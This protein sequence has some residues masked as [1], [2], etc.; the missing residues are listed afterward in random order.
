M[1]IRD[2]WKPVVILPSG[3]HTWEESA[4][5]HVL[6]HEWTHITRHDWAIASFAAFA[7][8]VFWFNPLVWWIERKLSSL[9]EQASDEASVRFSGD[10][11]GYAETLLQF[12]AAACRGARWI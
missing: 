5:R 6:V 8:S 1:C 10:P 3:W 4:L 12:A 11:Q 9:S 7:K 2:S